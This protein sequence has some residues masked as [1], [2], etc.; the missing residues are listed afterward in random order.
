MD[1]NL[2]EMQENLFPTAKFEILIR[3][4]LFPRNTEKLATREIK[5]LQKFH[6]ARY[7]L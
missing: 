2:P 7:P 1:R 3:E 6:A 5:L 4:S